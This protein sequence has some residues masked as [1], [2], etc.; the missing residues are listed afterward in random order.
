M[1]TVMEDLKYGAGVMIARRT[2]FIK[3]QG[4]PP[5][6]WWEELQQPFVINYYYVIIIYF[7]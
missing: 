3:L 7:F 6:K 4:N 1:M 5:F 2:R